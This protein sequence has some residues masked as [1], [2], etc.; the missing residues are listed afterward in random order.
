MTGTERVTKTILGEP[1]DRQPIYGWVSANLGAE[2]TDRFGSVEAFEDKYE[3]DIAHIFGGPPVF[4][5]SVLDSILREEGEI[6]PDVLLNYDYYIS[7]DNSSDYENI[8]QS[9]AFHKERGRFCYVQTPGFFE[10]FN[11][12]FGIQNQLMYLIMYTDEIEELYKRHADYIISF[13]DKAIDCG[14]DMI[15]ISDD[16]GSQKDLLFSPLLWKRLI[17]PNMK[18][19]IDYVHS[20]GVFVSLHSD[21]CIDKVADEIVSLGFDLVHPWQENAGMS[22]DLY[23]E[24]YSDKFAILGGICVQSALGVMNRRELE[25]EIRRIFSTLKGER[26]ICCTSH[27]VQNHCTMD[28]LEFAYDLIYKLARE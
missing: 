16:W 24:R 26:W 3:F 28:D 21:G 11:D 10:C 9:I 6:S 15:H 12:V 5:R 8:K 17:Y 27:F 25:A 22:L 13:A 18:R 14:A 7:P 20:R 2:I 19:V 23:K 4:K 1:T